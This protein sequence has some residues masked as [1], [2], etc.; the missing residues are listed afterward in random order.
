MGFR[1]KIAHDYVCYF[2]YEDGGK[3][4]E[5]ESGGSD[6]GCCGNTLRWVIPKKQS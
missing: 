4:V 3:A 2:M 1:I 5:T 6:W